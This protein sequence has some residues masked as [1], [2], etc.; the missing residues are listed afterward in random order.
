MILTVLW[1]VAITNAFNFLD[2]MDGLA[3]GIAATA[4][5]LV[6]LQW[7]LHTRWGPMR[8]LMDRSEIRV[9]FEELVRRVQ[10]FEVHADRAVRV[11]ST[12]VRG[13]ASLPVTFRERAGA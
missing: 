5:L 13:F 4:P 2:N 3:A 11:H 12:S 1:I 6:G 8:R 10:H 7:C 9:F